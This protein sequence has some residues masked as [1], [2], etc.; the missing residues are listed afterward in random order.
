MRSKPANL[1]GILSALGQ[2]TDAPKEYLR[3]VTA[4][5]GNLL[6]LIT[7]DDIC[8]FQADNKYTVVMT[9]DGEALIR[10]PIKELVQEVDPKLFWQI[11][12]STLVNVNAIAGVARDLRGHLNVRLK[13]RKETLPVSESYIHIFKQM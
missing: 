7:V 3:W 10:R 1:E 13:H 11:H 2:K 4:S 9:D 5:K 8:Y 12:R 6:T